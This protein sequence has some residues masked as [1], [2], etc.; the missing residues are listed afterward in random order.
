MWAQLIKCRVKPGTQA[1]VKAMIDHLVATEQP[2]S[3]LLQELAM[4][5]QRDPTSVYV[6][7]VFESQ[8]KARAREEDPRRKEAQEVLGSM[9]AE[10]LAGPPEFV[11]MEVLSDSTIQ[12]SHP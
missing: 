10:V 12:S 7:A 8:E 2:E 5:D 4:C 3:G 1:E 6:L 11:D 9:M